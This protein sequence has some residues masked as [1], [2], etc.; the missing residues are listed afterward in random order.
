[1]AS[2]SKYCADF[3]QANALVKKAEGGFQINP[4]DGGNWTGGEQGSGI[5][6]GTNWGVSAPVY[7]KYLGRTPT[8][9]DMRGMLQ[10]TAQAIYRADYWDTIHGNNMDNQSV[11]NLIY[12]AAINEGQGTAAIMAR[13]TLND[14]GA[15]PKYDESKNYWDNDIIDAIN[16]V[17]SEDFFNKYKSLRLQKYQND[18][19]A[20]VF[21]AGWKSRLSGIIFTSEGKVTTTAKV[22]T[23]GFFVALATFL[24]IYNWSNLEF[25][26]KKIFTKK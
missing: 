15:S 8:E 26:A 7:A 4:S 3:T 13:Q 18:P 1:M 11:A 24:I 23:G 20:S 25:L 9:A 5:L 22:V 17:D 14:L 12:D 6:V 16:K 19:N 21:L 10:S 2:L